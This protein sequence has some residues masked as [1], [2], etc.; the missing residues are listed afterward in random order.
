[1]PVYTVWVHLHFELNLYTKNFWPHASLWYYLCGSKTHNE[2]LIGA[3]SLCECCKLCNWLK[4]IITGSK[5]GIGLK[6]APQLCEF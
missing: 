2:A 4:D 5:N 6:N 1:M 3:K